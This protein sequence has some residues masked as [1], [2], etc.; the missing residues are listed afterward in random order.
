MFQWLKKNQKMT[1]KSLVKYRKSN[2]I[3]LT[4][5]SSFSYE[6]SLHRNGPIWKD[7][8]SMSVAINFMLELS[9]CFQEGL[10]WY[11]AWKKA[12]RRG[13]LLL[14]SCIVQTNAKSGW[15]HC[16][17]WH[18]SFSWKFLSSHYDGVSRIL[19]SFRD[20]L[21]GDIWL[22]QL[23]LDTMENVQPAWQPIY[24]DVSIL[25]FA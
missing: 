15:G 18:L 16:L 10:Y 8:F 23:I 13:D 24:R 6:E 14:F 3:G 5:C 4:R 11:W 25:L 2:E 19:L 9:C 17:R 12:K 22:L 1:I 7:I 21:Q 20:M